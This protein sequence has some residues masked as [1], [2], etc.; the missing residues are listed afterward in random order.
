[1]GSEEKK[2]I[3]YDPTNINFNYL[4]GHTDT[5]SSLKLVQND[6][7]ASGSADREI[8]FWNLTTQTEIKRVRKHSSPI[9]TLESFIRELIN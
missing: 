2:V 6:L 7:L 3:I 5:V 9:L 8:I 1:M 4:S